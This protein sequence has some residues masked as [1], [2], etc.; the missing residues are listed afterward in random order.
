MIAMLPFSASWMASL[1][2]IMQRR[3]LTNGQVVLIG[4]AEQLFLCDTSPHA[5]IGETISDPVPDEFLLRLYIASTTTMRAEPA[6]SARLPVPS[7]W[8]DSGEGAE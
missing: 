4:N 2:T 3:G 6:Y 7:P 1:R 5:S 8:S